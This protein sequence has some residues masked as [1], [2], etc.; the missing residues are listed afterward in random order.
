MNVRLIFGLLILQLSLTACANS[1]DLQLRVHSEAG[2]PVEGARVRGLFFNDQVLKKQTFDG[3]Q[4]VTD[5]RGE[6]VVSGDEDLYVDLIINKHGYYESRKRQV[7]RG[8]GKD[9]KVDVILRRKVEPIELYA[10]NFRGYIPVKNIPL[11]FDLKVGDWVIPH[12]SGLEKNILFLFEG[13]ATS[14]LNYWGELTIKF[15]SPSDGITQTKYPAGKNSVMKMP[16]LAPAQ[17]YEPSRKF[18]RRRS[19]RGTK[20]VFESN[21]NASKNNG[22]FLRINSVVDDNSEL[23]QANYLKISGDLKFDPR[24]ENGKGAA[25]LQMTYY[26]NP[27]INDRNLEFDP[28]RNLSTNLSEEERVLLP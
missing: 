8:S 23:V 21:L 5:A 26:Y 7:V 10:R 12:G 25:Y 6:A 27:V 9:F 4:A 20:A 22:Y 2:E 24:T 15:V 18:Y 28:T 13:E 17:G 14:N 3:H 11:G 1:V 16:Y 19:G